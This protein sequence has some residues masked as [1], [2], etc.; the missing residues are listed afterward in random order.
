VPSTPT[1]IVVSGP[2]AVGKSTIARGLATRLTL[3]LLSRDA[4]K[5]AL[6]DTLGY[7]DRLQS[8]RFGAA[9]AAGAPAD[10]SGRA[11]ES[12]PT[13]TSRRGARAAAVCDDSSSR[14]S[15]CDGAGPPGAE[16]EDTRHGVDDFPERNQEAGRCWCGREVVIV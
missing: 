13:S 9:A 14:M 11:D 16:G 4:I 5:E 3:P 7:G 2:P 15:Q 12:E 10:A 8:K 1:V 6:V